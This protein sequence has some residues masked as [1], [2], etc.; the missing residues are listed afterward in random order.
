VL[1]SWSNLDVDIKVKWKDSE[2]ENGGGWSMLREW[3]WDS[4]RRKDR[5]MAVAI[6]RCW[7]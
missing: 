1:S 2:S 4:E 3:G 6:R 5:W 7:G